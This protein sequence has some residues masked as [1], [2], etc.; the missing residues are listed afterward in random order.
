MD[1]EFATAMIE[2][3]GHRDWFLDD[4]VHLT[5]TGRQAYADL[6]REAVDGKGAS[7]DE[8]DKATTTTK[9]ESGG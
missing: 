6:I 1:R 5:E 7:K 4:G 2:S 8:G 9:P 3:D